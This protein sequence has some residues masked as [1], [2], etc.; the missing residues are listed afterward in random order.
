[1]DFVITH[2]TAL[3]YL[4]AQN[5]GLHRRTLHPSRSTRPNTE[6]TC[7]DVTDIPEEEPLHAAIFSEEERRRSPQGV[8]WHLLKLDELPPRSFVPVST[9]VWADSPEL[10]FVHMA[11][12]LP[13]VPLVELGYEL[14]G[15]YSRDPDSP[16]GFTD[17]KPLTSAQ[18]LTDYAD[19]AAGMYGAR[20]ARRAAR[21]VLDGAASPMET[22]VAML[23][24]LPSSRGGYSFEAPQLNGAVSVPTSMQ[25]SVGAKTLHCDLLWP[26][27]DAAIEYNSDQYHSDGRS[28]DRDSERSNVF[29][30]L[31]IRVIEVTRKDALDVYRFEDVVAKGLAEATGRRLRIRSKRFEQERRNLRT[32]LFSWGR[33]VP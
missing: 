31:H 19:A 30:R 11:A 20:Q 22:A 25:K 17:R 16:R 23:L 33:I 26:Q 32:A 15:S 7:Y 12:Q 6:L 13:F 8:T 9:K 27:Y 4:R 10:C 3:H 28:K 18:A 21:Y 2:N 24:C 14:C 5:G 1:M 29:E